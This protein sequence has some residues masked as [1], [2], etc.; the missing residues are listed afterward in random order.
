MPEHVGQPAPSLL[1]TGGGGLAEIAESARLAEEAGFAGAWTTE[2]YGRSATVS[3]RAHG[4]QDD[5]RERR[6]LTVLQRHEARSSRRLGA[7]TV[8]FRS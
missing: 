6:H 2:F 4:G 8:F 5:Q 1:I 3:R 7:D